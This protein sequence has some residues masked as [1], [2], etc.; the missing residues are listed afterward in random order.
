MPTDSPPPAA[1]ARIG[2][3]TF[4]RGAALSGAS[5]AV[6][7]GH[8]AQPASAV[9]TPP[10]LYVVPFY[11]RHQAGI[12]TPAPSQLLFVAFDLLPDVPAAEL[13]RLL[14]DWTAAA[15]RLTQGELTDVG[16]AQAPPES[17]GGAAQAADTD[18]AG[19]TLTFGVGPRVF[20]PTRGLSYRRPP[21]LV[22]LPRFPN[23]ALDQAR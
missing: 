22:P 21:R 6:A 1:A 13:Q 7:V 8:D 4:L 17:A 23:E 15:A 3:R 11:G 19:L 10:S 18:P 12:A 5:L 9:A 2:R 20:A 16:P 14:Q